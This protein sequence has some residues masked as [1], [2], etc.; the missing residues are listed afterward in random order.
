MDTSFFILLIFAILGILAIFI[1][2]PHHTLTEGEKRVKKE[3]KRIMPKGSK[4]L[5]GVLL[6]VGRGFTE[7]DHI[8]ITR[9]KIYVIETKDAHGTIQGKSNDTLW[10]QDIGSKHHTMRNP[11]MQNQ[12]HVQI[13]DKLIGDYDLNIENLVVFPNDT[14]LYVNDDRVI[15][16]KD[17][18][19]VLSHQTKKMKN[20]YHNAIFKEIKSLDVA[21]R[22]N[23]YRHK[24]NINKLKKKTK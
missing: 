7:I 9:S 20:K 3:I 4:S 24:R 8:V 11:L 17:M 6:K 2:I 14:K 22:Y 1:T 10:K 18:E 13:L 21:S 15:K 5:H 23:R 12:K 19:V 16:I